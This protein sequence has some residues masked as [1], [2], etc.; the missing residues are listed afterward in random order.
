LIRPGFITSQPGQSIAHIVS[1]AQYR[2]DACRPFFEML[3]RRRV[4]QTPTLVASSELAVIGTPA[5]GNQS[6]FVKRP[7]IVGILKDLPEVAKVVQSVLTDGKDR[8]SRTTM[9]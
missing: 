9:F 7:E 1:G 3:A 5:S 4:W 8:R 6:F 2:P